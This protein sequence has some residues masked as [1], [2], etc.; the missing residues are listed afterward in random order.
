VLNA[1]IALANETARLGYGVLVFCNSRAGCESVARWI[2][3]VM[4]E[5]HEI[6]QA[7]LEKRTD[8]ILTLRALGTGLDPV[9]KETIPFGVAFH[10]KFSLLRIFWRYSVLSLQALTGLRCSSCSYKLLCS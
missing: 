9:L 8:L 3:R 2:S 4:P 6:D 1:V 5:L 10:R 7:I